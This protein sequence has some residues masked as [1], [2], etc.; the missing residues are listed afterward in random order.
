MV[1]YRYDNERQLTKERE[2]KYD[3]IFFIDLYSKNE[4]PIL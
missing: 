4:R 2:R 3:R 1:V